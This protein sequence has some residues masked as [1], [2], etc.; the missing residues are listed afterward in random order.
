MNYLRAKIEL[1]T[2]SPQIPFK[3]M[4]VEAAAKIG[5]AGVP[6]QIFA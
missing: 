4:A 2:E 5:V 3:L 6:V 1:L